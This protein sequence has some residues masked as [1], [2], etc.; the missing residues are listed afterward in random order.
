MVYIDINAPL[1]SIIVLELI[2][3]QLIS[4][5]WHFFLSQC[6][7]YDTRNNTLLCYFEENNNP[8]GLETSELHKILSSFFTTAVAQLSECLFHIKE[9]WFPNQFRSDKDMK[10]DNYCSFT[11]YSTIRN[12]SHKSSRRDLKN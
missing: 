9:V 6:H 7:V 10:K 5:S 2:T 1:F 3:L 8:L 4:G 12:E 11:K